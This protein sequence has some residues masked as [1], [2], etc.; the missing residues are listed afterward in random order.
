MNLYIKSFNRPY[1]LERCIRSIYKFVSGEVKII[2]LD[3]GTPRKYLEKIKLEFPNVE[4]KCSENYLNKNKAIEENLRTGK[5]I[6]GFQIPTKLWKNAVKEGTEYFIMTEDDVWFTDYL[7]CDIAVEKMIEIGAVLIKLGWIT[8]KKIHSPISPLKNSDIQTIDVDVFA[9]TPF[10][11]DLYF[12]NKYRLASIV[13]IL[14]LSRGTIEDYWAMNALLMGLYRKDYWLHL[15]HYVDGRVDEKKQLKNAV[16]WYRKHKTPSSFAKWNK[17]IMNTTFIT[18]A[19]NSYRNLNKSCDIN[20]FNHIMN[21]AWYTDTFDPMENFPKD[22]PV[23]YYLKYLEEE[24]NQR[25]QPL[26]WLK[27]AENFKN[28]YRAQSVIVD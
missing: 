8:E 17:K 9:S 5:E 11:M 25:C 2:V 28:I 16:Q 22:I 23:S 1:Y 7:D 21:E 6:D 20:I 24:K 12:A 13:K 14:K 26:E 10:L 18:S 15:W 4:I 27:W 19:T 3:D